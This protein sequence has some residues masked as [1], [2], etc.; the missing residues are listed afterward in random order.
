MPIFAVQMDHTRRMDKYVLNTEN[1][2]FEI[3]PG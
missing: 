3:K 1:E 2:S